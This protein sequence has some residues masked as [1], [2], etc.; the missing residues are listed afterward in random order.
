[1]SPKLPPTAS[2]VAAR[3]GTKLHAPAAERN[4]GTLCDLL[5]AHAPRHGQALEIASGTGQH[6]VQF[7]QALPDLVW[8]PTEVEPARLA[9]VDAYAC[10]A[11]LANLN[12]AH[13]LDATREGWHESVAPQ[14]LI[15]LINLLHLIS[16]PKAQT[17]LMETSRALSPGGVFILYG[18]FKRNGT[19]VSEGD[20]AFDS[21]LRR[22]DPEIGYKDIAVI[23]PTLRACGFE[24]VDRIDMPANNLAFIATKR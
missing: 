12:P 8:Q 14:D 21:D 13:L 11:G 23:V 18:P 9:S 5:M 2:V 15:V 19:L 4:A 24:P 1:M 20:R 3:D 6:V 17:V 22:A 7:A 10:D 16:M